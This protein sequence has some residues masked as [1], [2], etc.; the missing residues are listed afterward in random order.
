M[1]G[2]MIRKFHCVLLVVKVHFPS[3]RMRLGKSSVNI[4]F[5]NVSYNVSE[6]IPLTAHDVKLGRDIVTTYNRN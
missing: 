5:S 3:F 6:S 2:W 1:Y 4:A